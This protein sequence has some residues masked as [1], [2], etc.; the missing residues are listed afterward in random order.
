MVDGPSQLLSLDQELA[1]KLQKEL[2]DIVPTLDLGMVEVA[3]QAPP[4]KYL[5][6]HYLLVQVPD[7]WTS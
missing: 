3:V 7:E 1:V 5:R 4:Y 2:R 6:E